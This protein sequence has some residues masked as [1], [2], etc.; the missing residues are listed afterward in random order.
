MTAGA[1]GISEDRER[2]SP[3]RSSPGV[4]ADHPGENGPA[5]TE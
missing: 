1:S 2:G 5:K 4:A 3:E